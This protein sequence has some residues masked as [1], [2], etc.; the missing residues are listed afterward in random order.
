MRPYINACITKKIILYGNKPIEIVGSGIIDRTILSRK[1]ATA[2]FCASLLKDCG[3][4]RAYLSEERYP[5][6]CLA[7]RNPTEAIP[8]F[9][10]LAVVCQG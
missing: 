2:K 7:E 9:C 4:L 10:W 1:K 3:G 6:G 5:A 8:V